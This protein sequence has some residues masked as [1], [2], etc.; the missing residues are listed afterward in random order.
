MIQFI[1]IVTRVVFVASIVHTLLPPWDFLADFPRIQKVYKALIY[2]IGYIA[3]NGRSTV[4]SSLSTQTSGGV[5]ES[6][7]NAT[8][9]PE[10]FATPPKP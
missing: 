8:S 7:A 9:A 10:K 1:N 2:I 4:Y 6:V 5:N 3:I